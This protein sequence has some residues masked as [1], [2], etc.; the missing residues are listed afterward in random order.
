MDKFVGFLK[1]IY[2]KYDTGEFLTNL[3]KSFI[4]IL[5]KTGDPI[6]SITSQATDETIFS[7]VDKYNAEFPED[8][9]FAAWECS[10][11]FGV[12]KYRGRVKRD[13]RPQMPQVMTIN[14][15]RGFQEK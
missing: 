12:R 8:A 14:R 7:L 6:D 9:P 15:N 10:P 1:S 13:N 5:D 2:D 11:R 3:S 4:V